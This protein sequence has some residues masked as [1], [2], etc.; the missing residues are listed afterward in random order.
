M[1]GSRL[2][3]RAPYL[4]LREGSDNSLVVTLGNGRQ[5]VPVLITRL[6]YVVQVAEEFLV[7]AGRGRKDMPRVI[8]AGICEAVNDAPW[9]YNARA[10]ADGL[11]HI[12][13]EIL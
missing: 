7:T 4:A 11:G 9:N 2:E 12:A 8:D 3:M 1:V 5:L 6:G 13:D 10:G